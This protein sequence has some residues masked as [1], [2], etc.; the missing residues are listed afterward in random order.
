MARLVK[1]WDDHGTKIIGYAQ[2]TI[3]ALA[4]VAGIIPAEHL[5]YWLAV[6]AVLTVY[7][8]K[9]NTQNLQS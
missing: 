3:A 2:G 1:L 5:K 4:G 9:V 6:S 8:G 7:R